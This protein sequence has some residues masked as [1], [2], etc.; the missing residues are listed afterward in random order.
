MKHERANL[1]PRL[2]EADGISMIPDIINQLS[3]ALLKTNK[4][5]TPQSLWY[6]ITKVCFLFTLRSVADAFQLSPYLLL[7]KAAL[8]WEVN[9]A[10]MAKG[11]KQGPLQ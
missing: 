7:S 11:E 9:A 6:V 1:K 2:S 3:Y 10:L 4:S 8:T 5:M